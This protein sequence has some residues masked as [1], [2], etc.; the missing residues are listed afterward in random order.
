MCKT[1]SILHVRVLIIAGNQNIG[2]VE[3]VV[4]PSDRVA[5]QV[6]LGA[7]L[8]LVAV[9]MLRVLRA[10]PR[11]PAYYLSRLILGSQVFEVRISLS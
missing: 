7:L 3:L 10:T 8:V 2:E 11:G 6:A 9:G 5:E 4:G 1:Y